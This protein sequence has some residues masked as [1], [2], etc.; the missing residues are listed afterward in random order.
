VIFFATIALAEG[1]SAESEPPQRYIPL[2]VPLLYF[3][4]RTGR[5]DYALLLTQRALAANNLEAAAAA[6]GQSHNADDLWYSRT[7][8]SAANR[9]PSVQLRVQAMLQALAPGERATRTAEAPFNAWYGLSALRASVNDMPGVEKAVREAIDA[10][11]HWF[12][13]HW[14]LAQILHAQGREEEA[15]REASLAIDLDAGK[16]PDVERA[17]HRINLP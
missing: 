1:L 17:L 10:H 6:Y 2:A 7:L 11:P 15:R 5:D 14:I 9:A 16:H 12:K 13:P 8:A 3:A 4:V